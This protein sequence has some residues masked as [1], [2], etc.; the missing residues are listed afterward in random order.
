MYMCMYMHMHMH[1]P[2]AAAATRTVGKGL[3][4]TTWFEES[5]PL[6]QSPRAG[7]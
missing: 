7:R 4:A 6:Q 3:R 2:R 1:M 5:H